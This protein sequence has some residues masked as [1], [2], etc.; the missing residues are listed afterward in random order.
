MLTSLARVACVLSLL[1]PIVGTGAQTARLHG[2]ISGVVRDADTG[3][4]VQKASIFAD[5]FVGGRLVARRWSQIDSAG[6]Y[7]I[8]SVAGTVRLSVAC[9]RVR[10]P[11]GLAIGSD[12]V[13]LRDSEMVRHDL[14]VPTTGCDKRPIRH[15]SG[16]FRGHYAPGF[17]SS[18]FVPCPVDAWFLPSDSLSSYAYDARLA[19]AEWSPGASRGL[20]W[21]DGAPRDSY[22]VPHFYVRWRGTVIG[23]G[24]YGHMGVSPFEFR[25]D[26]V[27]EIRPAG[28]HDCPA[29]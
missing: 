18:A 14:S 23:P 26:S 7:R 9:A 2:R 3:G 25:V 1:A 17:E 29:R 6:G 11:V 8:D 21:P 4:P 22:G 27:L 19:W 13:A 10:G 15:V 24:Q 12:S 20:V 16:I 28:P 5:D